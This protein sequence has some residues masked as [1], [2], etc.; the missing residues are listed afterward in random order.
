MSTSL[1]RRTNQSMAALEF[2]PE[3]TQMI[4]DTY[5]NG[6]NNEEFSVLME[7]AKARNL[8]PLFRQIFFVK[9]WDSSK[10]REVWAA[11]VSIDGLRAIAQRTGLYDGQDEPEFE[12]DKD[13]FPTLAKVKVYRKD[14][15]RPVVGV[16]Y[17]R[18]YAVATKD[19][20]LT[21]MWNSKPHVMIS[22][23]A[24]ALA[25]RKAFPEDTGGLYTPEEMGH[26][27]DDTQ[28]VYK[29]EVRASDVLEIVPKHQAQIAPPVIVEPV[30][31]EPPK[32]E[33][34]QTELGRLIKW[35]PLIKAAQTSEALAVIRTEIKRNP[36]SARLQFAITAIYEARRSE[37][38]L[39][40]KNSGIDL[41]AH[42]ANF[43]T[44]CGV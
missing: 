27:E 6:A 37:L 23:C 17:F 3:Q 26:K 13:G 4:R 5:A 25:I 24:E 43:K 32:A 41:D 36:L 34:D 28:P 1:A 30:R 29:A 20:G 39:G 44:A 2:S 35:A 33:T 19:G 22:K 31:E 40:I 8:N 11:Q 16:A 38:K 21:S 42:L 18:E 9:R 14:W 10:K 15:T 7:I 12:H